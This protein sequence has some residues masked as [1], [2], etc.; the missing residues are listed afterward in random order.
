[1]FGSSIS[2]F[3]ICV[4]EVIQD[5]FPVF[6]RLDLIVKNSELKRAL[7]RKENGAQSSYRKANAAAKTGNR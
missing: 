4:K 3:D 2:H 7:R 5:V 1:M 6:H